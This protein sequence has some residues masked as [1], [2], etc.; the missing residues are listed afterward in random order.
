MPK[1]DPLDMSL[2]IYKMIHDKNFKDALVVATVLYEEHYDDPEA[3]YLYGMVLFLSNKIERSC[4]A[5]LLGVELFPKFW[6]FYRLLGTIYGRLLEFKEAEEAYRKAIAYYSEN[7]KKE[8]ATLYYYL[9]D[10]MWSQ[11]NRDEAR[12]QWK[13]ALKIN[14]KCKEAKAALEETVN[15]YGEALA[16]DPLFDDLYHFQGIQLTRY[17]ELVGRNEFTSQ[18]EAQDIIA[19]MMIGWNDYV[20]PHINYVE[21]LETTERTTFF[22]NINLDFMEAVIRWK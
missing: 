14:P 22:K 21:N 17:F 12:K 8:K 1:N 20:A 9:G 2:K 10:T 3:H 7:D 15:D 13:Q 19:L 16:P 18:E 6:R 5:L 4:K 11:L